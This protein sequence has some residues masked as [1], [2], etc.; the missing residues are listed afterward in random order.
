VSG[1]LAAPSIGSEVG[2]TKT[3]VTAQSFRTLPRGNRFVLAGQ[4]RLGLANGFGRTVQVTGPNGEF[5]TEVL[6][7]LPASERFYGGG[8]TTVRGFALDTLGTPDTIDE[9]GF[10]LGGNAIVIFNAELR[11]LVRGPFSAV[12]FLDIGNVFRRASDVRLGDLRSAVGFGVRY[13]SPVGPIRVDL[14]FKTHPEVVAGRLER[15]TA[16]HI[17]LGQAF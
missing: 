8:D 1:Q 16:L 5:E 2:F 7:D 11:A 17:T 4:A 15:R 3:F 13:R 14:G 10:P 6:D 9:D 12:G